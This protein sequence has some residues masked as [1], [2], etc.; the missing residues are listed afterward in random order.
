LEKQI[1][2]FAKDDKNLRLEKQILRFAKDDKDLG[3]K[4]QILPLRRAQ[5]KDDQGLRWW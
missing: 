3:L 5:G 1:L 4:K 2:R